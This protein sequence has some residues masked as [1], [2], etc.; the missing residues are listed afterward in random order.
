MSPLRNRIAST[1]FLFAAISL[2]FCG[3]AWSAEDEQK[4]NAA[5]AEKPSG[6]IKAIPGQDLDDPAEPLVPKKPRTPEEQNRLDAVSHYMTG[7]LLEQRSEF[8]AALEEYKKAI[9]LDPKSVEI[10]RALVPLAFSLNQNDEAVKYALKAVELDPNDYQLLRRLG[11]HMANQRQVPQAI[12]LLEKASQVPQLKDNKAVRVLIN[13][14]LAI[15]YGAIGEPV[16]AADAFEMVFDA[17]QNPEKFELSPTQQKSLEANP[18][19]TYEQIG[20]AFIDAERPE[21]AV[22]AFEAAEKARKGKPGTLSYNLAQAYLATKQYDKA[23]EEIQKYFDAQLQ[24]KGRDAYE[25]LAKILLA[26]DQKAELITRLEKM[27]QDDARNTTLQYFLAEQYM[28]NNQ[29]EKAETLYKKT[30]EGNKDPEGFAGLASVYRRQNKPDELFD[31]LTQA[32]ESGSPIE[33]LEEEL[34]VIGTDEKLAAK[35]IELARQKSQPNNNQLRYAGARVAGKIAA[36]AKKFDDALSFY[37]SAMEQQREQSEEIYED[38]GGMYFDADDFA[39]S[40]KWYQKAVDDSAVVNKPQFLYRLSQ[41]HELAGN[42]DAALAAVRQ[43]MSQLGQDS[44]LLHFQEAWIYYHAK[45]NDEAIKKF[46][47]VITRFAADKEIVRRCQF[48]LSTLYVQQGDLRKGEEV[49]E[50]I[51]ADE[52]DDPSVNNDLG[53]L[54]ADHG[55]NLEK[56]K[57]MIQKAVKAEPEN[58][59]YLDSMGWVHYK[60]GEYQEALPH[61]EKAVHLPKGGDSTI[62]DHLG[63]CY[64]RLKQMDKAKDAWQKALEDAK[65]DAQPDEKLIKRI[66]QKLAGADSP[67]GPELP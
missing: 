41:V 61:L 49:L 26:K 20:Q 33:A 2:V 42:T 30:L 51:L 67:E 31:S 32:V 37:Q 17:L 47:E 40:A 48:I 4:P 5:Q 60:L 8:N 15:M 45:R 3:S 11:I 21:L 23:L 35:V 64:A 50:Q 54:Y 28:E 25:L 7:Q 58:P 55:K 18:Q 62:W 6:P 56:A 10:Y 65:K 36:A 16:K 29:L 34:Q 24:T 59:A 27:A 12:E 38:I 9:A 46:D 52:P 43:A 19:A 44:S 1:L 14:D 13:R 39:S 57:S 63:D 53:Y 66:E 22:K